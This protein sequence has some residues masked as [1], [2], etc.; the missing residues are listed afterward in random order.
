MSI[1]T[2]NDSQM[3]FISI[4]VTPGVLRHLIGK[5]DGVPM[6]RSAQSHLL[7]FGVRVGGRVSSQLESLTTWHLSVHTLYRL[8]FLSFGPFGHL[9]GVTW[10]AQSGLQFRQIS[11]VP[12][13]NTTTSHHHLLIAKHW[14]SLHRIL[15]SSHSI[16]NFLPT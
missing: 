6:P 3:P 7:A 9:M 10:S 16:L 11:I 4:S 14:S 8:V 2:R 15:I 13:I 5:V 12:P 1:R